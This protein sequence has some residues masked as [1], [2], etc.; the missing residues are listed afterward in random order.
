MPY[1]G[2]QRLFS[3]NSFSGGEKKRNN[4]K[5]AFKKN[6]A[7]E[8]VVSTKVTALCGI[9][10]LPK[11]FKDEQGDC[12]QGLR[13]CSRFNQNIY[14]SRANCALILGRPSK[15]RSVEN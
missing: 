14:L 6:G 8:S 12:I 15:F 13:H 10:A 1:T 7:E 3:V 5:T 4:Y 11:S 2:L 9:Q